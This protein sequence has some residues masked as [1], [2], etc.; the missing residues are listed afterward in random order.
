[1]KRCILAL[2]CVLVLVQA[3]AAWADTPN[4]RQSINYFM[5]YFNEAVVQAIHLK[6]YEEKEQ[7]H[8]KRPYTQEYIFFL[9][10]TGRIEKTLGLVL[11]LCDMYYIYN[12]TTYCFTKYEKHYIFDRI[13]NIIDTLKKIKETPYDVDASLV[14]DKKGIV[15]QN[16]AEFNKRIDELCAFV[17]TSLVVF[18]R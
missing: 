17:K 15:G 16:V 8:K 9:D 4:I 3:P 5:N 18:Q 6:E 7:L 14:E 1:M 13:D 10:M 11:N 12:K 2:A